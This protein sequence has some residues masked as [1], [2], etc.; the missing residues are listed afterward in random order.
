MPVPG[1]PLRARRLPLRRASRRDPCPA[2][3]PGAHIGEYRAVGQVVAEA[4]PGAPRQGV[5]RVGDQ[6]EGRQQA[7]GGAAVKVAV[8]ARGHAAPGRRRRR[9]AAGLKRAGNAALPSGMESEHVNRGGSTPPPRAVCT[10]SATEAISAAG[11]V[12]FRAVNEAAIAARSGTV[13][14]AAVPDVADE[15]LWEGEGASLSASA[16]PKGAAPASSDARRRLAARAAA[17]QA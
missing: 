14:V 4:A 5:M 2:R 15:A 7:C 11:S 17:A 8:V 6:C 12:A 9:N 10:A 1:N 16:S 13:G 3:R